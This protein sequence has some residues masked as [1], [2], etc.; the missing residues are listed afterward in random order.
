MGFIS[1]L[2]DYLRYD[3]HRNLGNSFNHIEYSPNGVDV[4][5]WKPGSDVATVASAQLLRSVGKKFQDEIDQEAADKAAFAKFREMIQH[6]QQWDSEDTTALGPYDEVVLGEFKKCLWEF[7]NPEGYPLMRQAAIERYADFG[8]GAATGAEDCSFLTKVGDSRLY[9]PNPLVIGLFDQWVRASELRLDC[10]IARTLRHGNPCV[11]GPEK[12]SAVP[13][14]AKISRLVKKEP[15]LGMFFQKGVQRI[16]EDRIKSY[17]HIDISTQPLLNAGLARLGSIDGSYC[18]IDLESASDCISMEMLGRF[19]PNSA[20]NWLRLL[21]SPQADVEGEI[22]T[23]P[24]MAT[25]GNAFTFPMQIV[26][27]AS[28]VVACYKALGIPVIFNRQ[29]EYL[30]GNRV[31]ASGTTKATVA[32]QLQDCGLLLNEALILDDPVTG[33]P[34]MVRQ[35][36]GAPGNFGV[37][38]DDIVIH[39]G[40][41]GVVIRLLTYLGFRVNL[42][43]SFGPD[44]G[45]FRESC[46]ADF[47]CGTNVRGVYCKS[48]KTVQDKYILINNLVEWSARHGIYLHE[49]I[50]WLLSEVRRVEVPA[51]ENPDAG[52]RVPL[53]CVKTSLVYR[54]V[55]PAKDGKHY[56]GSY[57]YKRYVPKIVDRPV[58]VTQLNEDHTEV[59]PPPARLNS[60]AVLIAAIRGMLRSNRHTL[61]KE[62]TNSG[63]YKLVASV[64]PCWDY[65]SRTDSKFEFS[66]RWFVVAEAYFRE[67]IA[68][69]E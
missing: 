10:E 47:Y 3:L 30:G 5:G 63:G 56:Q 7:F 46:G 18:T 67:Q 32:Q 62:G 37:F 53:C 48:A 43:K 38:G 28:V 60:A 39:K 20:M 17:F 9:A 69:L 26:I 24:M 59:S 13:K 21:R 66:L 41:W 34:L 45:P 52:I 19:V 8:P 51:W 2:C 65:I 49:T 31:S 40:A 42:E 14:T 29:R 12:I 16:L 33:E 35:G 27:F 44:D 54:A 23:L 11:S 25:M 15:S 64:A 1:V 22:T 68:N 50:A 55:R 4:V 6:V 61:R 36:E 58:G 57:L